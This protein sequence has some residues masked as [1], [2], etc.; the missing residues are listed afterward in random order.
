MLSF[1]DKNR[2]ANIYIIVKLQISFMMICDL[3]TCKYSGRWQVIDYRQYFYVPREVSFSGVYSVMM[4]T[5]GIDQLQFGINYTLVWTDN[6]YIV[7]WAFHIR[8]QIHVTLTVY[9]NRMEISNN[10]YN[11]CKEKTIFKISLSKRTI[12]IKVR[13]THFSWLI[14]AWLCISSEKECRMIL[15]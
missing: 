13:M 4:Y 1:S 11:S 6:W 15:P 10:L 14:N 12:S 3:Y 7:D 8:L 2:N 9:K 5:E